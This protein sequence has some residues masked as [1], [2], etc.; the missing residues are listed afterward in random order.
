MIVEAVRKDRLPG[1]RNGS[2]IYNLYKLK[3]RKSRK[4]SSSR[5]TLDSVGEMQPT[6]ADNCQGYQHTDA[7]VTKNLIQ[8][9]IEIDRLEHLIN[10]RG[11]RIRNEQQNLADNSSPFQRLSKIGDEIVEQ[12]VEWTKML[13]FYNELTVEV[14]TLLL[15]QRWSELVSIFFIKLIISILGTFKCLFLCALCISRI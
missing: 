11:L 6:V 10:L 1:G 3:Y 8:E 12:L 5:Q 14:H 9:L 7:P 13:P 2:S 15:T 4:N